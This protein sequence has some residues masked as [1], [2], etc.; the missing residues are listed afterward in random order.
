MSY[1]TATSKRTGNPCRQ[2]VLPGGNGKCLWHGGN[3]R[4]GIASGTFRTGKYSKDLPTRLAARYQEALDDPDLHS[5]RHEIALMEMRLQV[6]NERVA[7]GDLGQ[8]WHDLASA[9]KVF[10]A[11]RTK[12]DVEAMRKALDPL[13]DAIRRGNT[14]YLLWQNIGET[15]KLLGELRMKEQ[16]RLLDLDSVIPAERAL[17]LF[18]LLQRAVYT[19][20][21]SH[22]D[23]LTARHILLALQEAIRGFAPGRMAEPGLRRRDESAVTLDADTYTTLSSAAE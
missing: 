15:V 3:S 22:A 19:A 1:C 21:T 16:K 7:Q 5:L 8:G 9:W 6:L 17:L 2:Q 20:V 13:E 23:P 14:D 12:G 11:A 4:I 10:A 18:G